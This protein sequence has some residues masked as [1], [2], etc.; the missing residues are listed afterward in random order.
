MGE[1]DKASKGLD[2]LKRRK[3][4]DDDSRKEIESS[5]NGL[6]SDI[7]SLLREIE[8]LRKQVDED[9]HQIV[10]LLHERDILN[11][12]VIKADDRTKKQTELVKRHDGAAQ[13]LEKEVGGVKELLQ[14]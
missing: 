1:K 6:K 9:G 11:K 5:R 4:L 14:D 2:Q 10:D 8:R 13:E 7:Q 3:Q 12:N